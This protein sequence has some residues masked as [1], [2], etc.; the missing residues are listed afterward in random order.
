MDREKIIQLIKRKNTFPSHRSF[1]SYSN[2]QL[3]A[4]LREIFIEEFKNRNK[5]LRINEN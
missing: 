4:L 1:A 2:E 3:R 5:K